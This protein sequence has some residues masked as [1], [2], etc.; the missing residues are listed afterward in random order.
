MVW[1]ETEATDGEVALFKIMGDSMR[2]E[3]D[4]LI[5]VKKNN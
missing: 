1:L 5:I 3:M 4:F 2:I